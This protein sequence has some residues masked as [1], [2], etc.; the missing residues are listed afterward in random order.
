[1]PDKS[2]EEISV[3]GAGPVGCVLATLLAQRGFDV[4]V[5]EKRADMRL[6]EAGGGR[7]INLVLTDRGLQALDRLGIRQKVLDLTVPVRGRMMHS[8]DGQLAYQPYGKD[9]SECNYSV[10]R[11]MLNEF[12]LDAAAEAGVEIHFQHELVDAD[13]DARHLD[14]R[15]PDAEQPVRIDADIVIGCD[16]APSALRQ[17]L[18]EENHVT[19]DVEFMDWGYKELLFP[20]ADDGSYRM[21][22]NALHIWP[23][24]D[25]FLMGLANLDGS[26][27]GTIYLPRSGSNS[28]SSLADPESVRDF[29]ET[30]YPDAIP[31]LGDFIDE[32][33]TH[34][35]GTLGTVRAAP[36]HIKGRVLLVGDAAHGI[37]P[38][39]GQ[40]LNCGFEDCAVFDDL[41]EENLPFDQ[42][43]ERFYEDR[44]PNTDAIADMAL[45]NA[46]EMGEKVANPD[47]LKK[48]KVESIIEQ[49]L[50]TIYRSRYATVMYS[51]IPY[52]V[53]FEIGEQQKQLLTELSTD[54]DNPDDVDLDRARRLIEESLTPLYDKYGVDLDF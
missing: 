26:F 24:G 48:K 35:T 33:I 4:V 29:F 11:D 17:R 20:T 46:V 53:A 30:H 15:V 2:I 54:L 18:V 22:K 16:G 19:E 43:F 47:F 41:L 5:Y 25:H 31:V 36:W 28:F 44:K 52:R 27:T 3:V 51:Q 38:F 6:R 45:E 37:V 13:F 7:S 50:G 1:M 34:P 9:E 10:S 42:L 23:R 12:L 49:S 8:V 21:E 14:F 40:A 32:F 39:F